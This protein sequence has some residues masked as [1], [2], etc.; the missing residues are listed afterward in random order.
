MKLWKAI[1]NGCIKVFFGKGFKQKGQWL[2]FFSP[3]L[4]VAMSLL[5][6]RYI[7]GMWYLFSIRALHQCHLWIND[8]N[9]EQNRSVFFLCRSIADLYRYWR[10][11]EWSYPMFLNMPGLSSY[12]DFIFNNANFKTLINFADFR[13]FVVNKNKIYYY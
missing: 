2:C 9:V 4:L 8:L 5:A 11:P 10:A 1:S 6:V 13:F 3:L 12:N 7:W